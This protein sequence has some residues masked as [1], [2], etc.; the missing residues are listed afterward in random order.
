MRKLF[1]AVVF[2]ASTLA[3]GKPNPAEYAVVVHVQSSGLVSLCN[4]VMGR[5]FCEMRQHLNVVIDG[6]KYEMNSKDFGDIGLVVGDY[7][8]KLL[9][10]NLTDKDNPP[11]S[12]V[13]N[14]QYEF[15][16]PD[17]KTCKFQVVGG[18]E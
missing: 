8:A 2:L 12:Y 5:P 18:S 7:K 10:D 17:G 6:K 13:Y 4:T 3:W 16:F 1:F 11:R 9:P 14:Q 15:L